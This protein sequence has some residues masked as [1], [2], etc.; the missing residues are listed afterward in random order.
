MSN[1]SNQVEITSQGEAKIKKRRLKNFCKKAM[2]LD[3]VVCTTKIQ[4]ISINTASTS[5]S[6]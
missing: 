2:G 1:K 5:T 6:V 4:L 3:Q